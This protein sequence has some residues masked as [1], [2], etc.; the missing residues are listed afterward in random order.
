MAEPSAR[1][2]VDEWH[3]LTEFKSGTGRNIDPERVRVNAE[4]TS[5]LLDGVS[6]TENAF[7]TEDMITHFHENLQAC[8]QNINPKPDAIHPVTPI[9]EDTILKCDE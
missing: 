1:R 5:L 4:E 8:F 7:D 6:V 2:G 9:H 3:N